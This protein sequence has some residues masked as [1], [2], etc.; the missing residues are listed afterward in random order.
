MGKRSRWSFVAI[1]AVVALA[2]AVTTLPAGA[3]TARTPAAAWK[4][5]KFVAIPGKGVSLGGMSCPSVHLCVADGNLGKKEGIF[6]TTNPAGGGKTWKFVAWSEAFS[7]GGSGEDVS[8]DQ[9]GVH[10]DCAL[11]GYA[12][13]KGHP[14]ESYGGSLFQSGNPTAPNWGAALVDTQTNGDL[15]AVSCWSGPACAELDDAGNVL[16]TA[17]ATVTSLTALFPAD[18]GYSG[19][20]SIGCAPYVKG[21]PNIF[22]AA[23]DQNSAHSVGW[24]TDPSG[25][26]WTTASIVVLAATS[27]T[28]LPAAPPACVSSPST[29]TPAPGPPVSP[30]PM[31]R[32]PAPA[33]SSPFASSP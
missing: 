30:C 24:S 5:S 29:P 20:W 4:W 33:G 31:A 7:G 16:T 14:G 23:V 26:K 1:A 2:G 17:G 15:G 10:V 13:I 27:W 18:D 25:G 9:A 8:C 3:A 19:I 11:A 32:P 6:Y 28:T 21:Q 12:P 22:C